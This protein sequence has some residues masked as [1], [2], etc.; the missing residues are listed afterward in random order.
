M[1]SKVE[2]LIAEQR[3]A[4]EDKLAIAIEKRDGANREI[5]QLRAE[6]AAA[7]RLHVPRRKKSPSEKLEELIASGEAREPLTAI[8]GTDT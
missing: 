4:I 6:L 5:K 2:E 1:A 7:P 3:G 8:D